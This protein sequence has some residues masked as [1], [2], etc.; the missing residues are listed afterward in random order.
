MSSQAAEMAQSA[1]KAATGLPIHRQQ[2]PQTGS[3]VGL[4]PRTVPTNSSASNKRLLDHL[5]FDTI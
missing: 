4:K 2:L 5:L 1:E 3:Y